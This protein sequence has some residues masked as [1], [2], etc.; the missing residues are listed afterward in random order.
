[1]KQGSYCLAAACVVAGRLILFVCGFEREDYEEPAGIS[2]SVTANPS[3]KIFALEFERGT[4]LIDTPLLG[5]LVLTIVSSGPGDV[6]FS[7]LGMIFRIMPHRIVA[8]YAGGGG[9]YNHVFSG[10]FTN[11]VEHGEARSEDVNFWSGHVRRAFASRSGQRAIHRCLTGVRL[12]RQLSNAGAHRTVG[13]GY[14]QQGGRQKDWLDK[15]FCRDTPFELK[16]SFDD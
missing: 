15:A 1:M 2:F 3:D 13:L 6:Y 5:E 14:G 10:S 4:W 16:M 7:G 11:T 9:S 12:G 8:P